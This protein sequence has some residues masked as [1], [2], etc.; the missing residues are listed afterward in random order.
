MCTSNTAP[1]TRIAGTTNQILATSDGSNTTLSLPSAVVFPGTFTNSDFDLN[2]KAAGSGNI[3]VGSFSAELLNSLSVGHI[4]IGRSAGNRVQRGTLNTIVGHQAAFS[5]FCSP[6]GVT[7]IGAQAAGN[8]NATTETDGTYVGYLAGRADYGSPNFVAI[9]Y[10]AGYSSTFCNGCMFVGD[11][12]GYFHTQRLGPP[13]GSGTDEPNTYVGNSCGTNYV[14]GQGNVAVGFQ[15]YF[16]PQTG[17]PSGGFNTAIGTLSMQNGVGSLN[18]AVGRGSLYGAPALGV[19]AASTVAVGESSLFNYTNAQDSTAVGARAM[20]LVTAATN[21][22][23]VGRSCMPVGTLSRATCV[24]AFC[25]GVTDS[26]AFG[27]SAS[28]SSTCLAIGNRA[29]C[30][31]ANTGNWGSNDFPYSLN[32]F[33][34]VCVGCNGSAP[35][36]TNSG[37]HSAT[38]IFQAN[39]QVIDTLLAGAGITITGSGNSRTI[40][41]SAALK[42]NEY[43]YDQLRARIEILESLLLELIDSDRSM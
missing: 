6:T 15:A 18:T 23:C 2:W 38:R 8:I 43:E 12:S 39:V 7:A 37:D 33:S 4:S 40:S 17:S 30:S 16:G 35:L 32:T 21:S 34:Y 19:T 41:A 11:R 9:G 14:S 29:S 26:V 42:S 1:V 20:L 36:N 22:T 5:S 13:Y 24:G 3:K 28:A 10:A 31:A 27:F 25:T